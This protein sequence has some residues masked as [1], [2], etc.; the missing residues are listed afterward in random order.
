[1]AE[2][3]FDEIEVGGGVVHVSVKFWGVVV[4]G[5]LGWVL[6]LGLG[7]VGSHNEFVLEHTLSN[8]EIF[9]SSE[10]VSVDTE[11]WNWVILVVTG[12]LLLVLILVASGRI[13]NWIRTELNFCKIPFSFFGFLTLQVLKRGLH[14]LIEWVGINIGWDL[15]AIVLL[16]PDPFMTEL[17]FS[18][19]E[20]SIVMLKI[21]IVSIVWDEV[22]LIITGI[23]F[24]MFVLVATGG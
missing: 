14:V 24:H 17:F 10:D 5:L 3:T 12:F 23:L 15:W 8:G 1:V 11:V 6:P 20:G 9:V 21:M 7:L 4:I 2:F 19:V 16:G 18:P 22:V 13:A